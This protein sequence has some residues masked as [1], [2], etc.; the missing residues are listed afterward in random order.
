MLLLPPASD[1]GSGMMV[2]SYS[3]TRSDVSYS[4]ASA[5]GRM[6][7]IRGESSPGC[8]CKGAEEQRRQARGEDGRSAMNQE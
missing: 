4:A 3:V 7:D 1:V 5:A 6:R 2:R 8:L